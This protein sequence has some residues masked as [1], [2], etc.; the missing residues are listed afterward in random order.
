[1]DERE[2]RETLVRMLTNVR[3]VLALR[4]SV[5]REAFTHDDAIHWRVQRA[6]VALAQDAERLPLGLLTPVLPSGERTPWWE[7]LRNQ[8][9]GVRHGFTRLDWAYLWEALARDWPKLEAQ[10]AQLVADKP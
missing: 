2:A 6:F 8:G 10:L 5:S 4:G 9:W 3:E 1:V 7:K